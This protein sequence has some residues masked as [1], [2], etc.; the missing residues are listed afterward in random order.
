[1][2]IVCSVL[3]IV[4][5]PRLTCLVRYQHNHL[6][7]HHSTSM[8]MPQYDYGHS[9]NTQQPPMLHTIQQPPNSNSR[10]VTLPT[11]NHIAA[12]FSPQSSRIPSASHAGPSSDEL[13]DH[14]SSATAES[15]SP[16]ETR[17]ETSSV[18]IACRQWS[19]LSFP[20]YIY[21]FIKT[22]IMTC[23]PLPVISRSRKIRCDSTRPVCNNCARRSNECEY[24][25]VPKRR[26]PDKRPGTRQRSCKKRPADGSTPPRP[27]RKRTC[28]V[29]IT[30][31]EQGSDTPRSY[32]PRSS[33]PRH[34]NQNTFQFPDNDH[35]KF[36]VP[37]PSVAQTEQ[38]NWWEKILRTHT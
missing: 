29:Q 25:L 4:F 30:E 24:D 3:S 14:S 35:R 13:D 37:T 15:T 1:M 33:Y 2:T 32:T 34:L 7:V 22:L 5:N 18:V 12:D 27:K 17:K 28:S 20:Q 38:K 10:H 21:S 16:K 8:I 11:R 9:L 26:G 36:P 6:D 23:I 19:V 31:P